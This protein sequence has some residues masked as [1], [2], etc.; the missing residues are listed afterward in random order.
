M[1][2]RRVTIAFA[3]GVADV[4]LARPEKM[5]AMDL[6]MY[7]GIADA[8]DE[9]RHLKGLRCVVLSGEG[10]CFCAGVDLGRLGDEPALRDLSP[11]THGEAN[12]FQNA[13]WGWRT[14]P[15]PVIAAVHG[16]AYGAG[17]QVMLGADIRIVAPDARLSIMETRWG[18]VP[19]VAGMALI[20]GLLRDDIAR[21]L[22]YTARILNG[23]EAASLGLVTRTA[24]DP[25]AEA[26][27]L[28]RAIA[29]QSPDAIRAAKRLMNALPDA[30]AANILQAE[31][32]EQTA[33][34]ASEGHRETVRAAA[35]QRA[36][37]FRD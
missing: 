15:V 14:L 13:A 4:R 9:L 21:E 32:A 22:I 16:V 1:S 3:D 12:L 26:M 11:R 6:A 2:E 25:H 27:A 36:P 24:A 31:A 18:L 37:L 20:R 23:E 28:A 7:Q 17:A 33:L 8:L 30:T 29:A 5:N 34:L 10:R 35:E 19:D